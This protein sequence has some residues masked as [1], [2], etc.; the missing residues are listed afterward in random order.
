MTICWRFYVHDLTIYATWV[1]FRL[2]ICVSVWNWAVKP[3][4][5]H[6]LLV[7][8]HTC[9]LQWLS[10][11]LYAVIS[12]SKTRL[13]LWQNWCREKSERC[14]TNECAVINIYILSSTKHNRLHENNRLQS[15]EL[16]Y[17]L[18]Y[19]SRL[20]LIR[21]TGIGPIRTLQPVRY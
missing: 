19:A 9:T 18:Q 6:C 4:I 12:E 5:P 17:S 15:N 13:R 20:C 11:C 2:Y 7:L 16:T 3:E 21:E 8:C 10:N 1:T 14:N